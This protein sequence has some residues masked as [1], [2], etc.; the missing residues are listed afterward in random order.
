MFREH[1][2]ISFEEKINRK[3]TWDDISREKIR[4]FLKEAD[5]GIKKIVPR[6]ILASLN[7]AINEKITNAGVLFF[8]K[9]IRQFIF[10]AQMTFIAFKGSD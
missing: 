7:V 10:H 9:N 5:I 3:A 8:A 4:N 1:E 2:E 6:D